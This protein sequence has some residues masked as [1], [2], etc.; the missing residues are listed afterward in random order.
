MRE[1]D[2]SAKAQGERLRYLRVMAGLKREEL[3]KMAGVGKTSISVWEHATADT[4]L[5]SMRSRTKLLKAIQEAGVTCTER[6]LR[7]GSGTVPKLIKDDEPLILQSPPVKKQF[8]DEPDLSTR[9]VMQLSEEIK[10]FTSLGERTVVTKIDTSYLS[11]ALEVGDIVGGLWQPS[12]ALETGKI[13]IL[14]LQDKLQVRYVKPGSQ[15]G[16]FHISY[17]PNSAQP[18]EVFEIQD[19]F[20]ER[21]AP[22]IRVWR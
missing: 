1:N 5:M 11:P 8:Q 19:V 7:T 22:V 9:L 21:V 4:S 3:A 14:K 2:A 17:L 6:W 13:C 15:P 16:L 18:T 20:I 10:F 12:H